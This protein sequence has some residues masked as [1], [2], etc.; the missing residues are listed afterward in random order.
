MKRS[1]VVIGG[2]AAGP[3]MA[4]KARR[5]DPEVPITLVTDE[6]II[7][8]AACGTPYYLGGTFKQRDKLLV[9]EA[10]DFGRKNNVTMLTGHR[11][12]KI[13]RENHQVQV[14]DQATGE[15]KLLDYTKLGI[16]TGARPFVPPLPGLPADGVFTLRS[17]TDAFA[18]D[19]YIDS[20]NVRRAVIVGAGYIGLEMAEQFRERG[21][22]ATV[23][24]LM[25]QVLPRFDVP[26]AHAVEKE[27]ERLGVEVLLSTKVEGIEVDHRN[28][29]TGVKTSRGP[30]ATEL[31]IMSIGVRPNT[32]LAID[33][34]LEIGA[35]KAI[36]VD[37]KMRTSD[38]D[39]YAAGDCAEQTHL[40]DGKPTWIPLGS[41][42]NKQARVAAINMTGGA[43]TFPGVIGTSLV[44]V[45]KLNVGGTGLTEIGLQTAG[46]DYES[47]IV[48]QGDRPG[49]MP[50]AA[51]VTL[52][53]HADRRTR[54]VLG[55]QI[56]GPGAVDKRVDI[57]A[58]AIT[59]EMTVDQVS[60]L[61]LGYA[62]P[63]APALDVVITAANV[64][65]S[66]LDQRLHGVM[67]HKLAEEPQG[68]TRVVVDVREPSEWSTGRLKG[69]KHIP[70]GELSERCVELDRDNGEV[71][72]YCKGGL[73]SVEGYR[74]LRQAGFKNVRSL[75]GGVTAWCGELEK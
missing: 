44:R 52:I 3:K 55:A 20:F 2:V 24:E 14:R 42:A 11:A 4:A 29:V 75:D 8:Y 45:G 66:K 72:V 21:L 46:F 51:E 5:E 50:G 1:I 7:S 12:T 39:I 59:A 31:V 34:G 68:E 28:R 69:A 71:V 57:L 74:K 33:A 49:Y 13:D 70:L 32:E 9:R 41:T 27:L 25:P 67:P 65:R 64:M 47:V 18:I 54:R 19:D 36:R 26:L 10:A 56:Y 61:D 60:K 23:V 63:F 40:V 35:T 16:A 48:P 17:V 6:P 22:D 38:P 53:L 73:R 30:I 43:D 37:E 15:E 58:T 62:P